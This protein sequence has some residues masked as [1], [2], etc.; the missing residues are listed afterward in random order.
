MTR[1][2]VWNDWN[3]PSKSG[4][5]EQKW[6]GVIEVQ[7]AAGDRA[8]YLLQAQE[9]TEKG[10]NAEKGGT[11]EALEIIQSVAGCLISM[12]WPLLP[13]ADFFLKHLNMLTEKVHI[14]RRL[15]GEPG[16]FH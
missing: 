16:A 2:L 5:Y 6:W 14:I 11:N 8:L 15:P 4:D 7:N 12:T 9:N 1:Q 13:T 3:N 10:L